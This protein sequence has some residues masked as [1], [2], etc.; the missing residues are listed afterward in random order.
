[1]KLSPPVVD[2]RKL[3]PSNIGSDEFRHLKWIIFWPLFGFMFLFVERI[4][5]PTV[6]H[7]IHC[8]L[9]DVI[10]FN[11]FFLIPYFY[12]FVFLVGIHIY[13]LLYDTEAF[14][15]LMKFVTVTFTLTIIFYLFY[16]T[17]QHLRPDSFKRDN[18][19]TRFIAEFYKFDTDTNVCPSLHVI[20]SLAAMFAGWHCKRLRGAGWKIF[21]TFSALIISLSTM[22]LK[23]HSA[24]DVMAAFPI[25]FAAYY[26]IFIR[27]GKA[28]QKAGSEELEG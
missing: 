21:F 26:F 7:E 13:T 20:G 14:V 27:K 28:I 3:R 22:F 19:I 15:K 12:W 6:Y 10:P 8:A 9:D 17:C 11:E 16:P 1:M 24:V 23:Q 18:P 4:Y 5:H 2:Y 25:S